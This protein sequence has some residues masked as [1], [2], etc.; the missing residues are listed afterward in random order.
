MEENG[1]EWNGR[2]GEGDGDGDYSAVSFPSLSLFVF[3]RVCL[4]SCVCDCKCVCTLPRKILRAKQ[5]SLSL[6]RRFLARFLF[7]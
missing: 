4:V 2:E 3:W 7:G 1:R 6:T 5:A